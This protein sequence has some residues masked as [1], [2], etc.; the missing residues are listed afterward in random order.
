MQ[1][2]PICF[3]NI[4]YNGRHVSRNPI[5][6][7]R[8]DRNKCH[9]AVACG[10]VTA[11]DKKREAIVPGD[12]P[13]SDYK[14]RLASDFSSFLKLVANVFDMEQPHSSKMYPN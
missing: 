4:P 10:T 3:S 7:F 5:C 14:M 13:I 11:A 9:L 8:N 1:I 6:H 12:D 2:L